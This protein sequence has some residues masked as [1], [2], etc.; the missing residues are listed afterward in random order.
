MSGIFKMIYVMPT[1]DI[2][3]IVE[4]TD[5]KIEGQELKLQPGA[6]EEILR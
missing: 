3:I 5:V 6:M 2:K 1:S 4:K